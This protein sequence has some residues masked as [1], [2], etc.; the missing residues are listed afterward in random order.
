MPQDHLEP[1]PL[2]HLERSGLAE[3]RFGSELVALDQDGDG[4]T[5]VLRE[6]A[7]GASRTAPTRG[8]G[9]CSASPWPAPTT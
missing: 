7:T 1:V 8:C 9:A 5:V 6:R 4:V 3:V 2:R